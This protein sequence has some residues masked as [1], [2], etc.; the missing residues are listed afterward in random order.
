[1]EFIFRFI[2]PWIDEEGRA[3]V[4]KELAA[5]FELKPNDE[6]RENNLENKYFTGM[7]HAS[8]WSREVRNLKF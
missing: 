5:I 3:E 2:V 8:R 4:R 7:S 1:M 6:N